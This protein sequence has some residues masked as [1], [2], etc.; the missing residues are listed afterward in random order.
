MIAPS[1]PSVVTW[2][3]IKKGAGGGKRWW[4]V[5]AVHISTD[6]VHWSEW[7]LRP[8]HVDEVRKP[9]RCLFAYSFLGAPVSQELSRSLR[10]PHLWISCDGRCRARRRRHV[11]RMGVQVLGCGRH[12]GAFARSAAN[13]RASATQ[14]P[15]GHRVET[16]IVR[17]HM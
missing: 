16:S 13:T 11:R 3:H 14:A 5:D 17:F 9:W 12:L 15:R 4:W 8:P 1:K 6:H 2:Y 10:G 7:V